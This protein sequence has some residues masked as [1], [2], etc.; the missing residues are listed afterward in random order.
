[1]TGESLTP[2]SRSHLWHRQWQQCVTLDFGIPLDLLCETLFF[3]T[4][5]HPPQQW[6]GSSS[7]CCRQTKGKPD[8][9]S[10]LLIQPLMCACHVSVCHNKNMSRYL[11]GFRVVSC[12]GVLTIIYQSS[13]LCVCQI[14]CKHLIATQVSG[15]IE[16]HSWLQKSTRWT[17]SVISATHIW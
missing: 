11:K 14:G 8:W 3:F 17:S 13:R 4:R 6:E 2:G 5:R 7:L 12:Y 16:A 9:T 10:S 15:L 1:M